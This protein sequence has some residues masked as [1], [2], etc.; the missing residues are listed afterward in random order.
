LSNRGFSSPREEAL[1]IA[2]QTRRDILSAKSDA[3]TILRACLLIANDLSK[4]DTADWI[5]QEL[6]GYGIEKVPKYRIHTCPVYGGTYSVTLHGFKE[7]KLD[8]SVHYLLAHTKQSKSLLIALENAENDNITVSSNTIEETLNTI[9]DRCFQFLNETITELQF[10]GAVEFLM[11]EIRRKTDEKLATFDE[12]IAEETKSLY[13]NLTS[14]NPADWSKVG[15]SSRKILKFLADNVYP[16]NEEK[17]TAKDGRILNVNDSCYINRLYAFVD[18]S[19]PS[20]EKK[21]IGAQ[22]DYLESYLRQITEY[23]QMAE[24][25]PSIDKYHAN[26]LAIHTYLIISDILRQVQEKPNVLASSRE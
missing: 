13:L 18:Q 9:V 4:K 11:E 7:V 24:H 15:H 22:M 1:E 21:F 25:N 17:Y 23:A 10:G 3:S 20:D 16:P 8:Y 6:S 26:M 12:R 19:F 2:I 5:F 14:T